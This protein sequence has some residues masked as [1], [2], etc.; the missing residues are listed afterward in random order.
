MNCLVLLLAQRS[1]QRIFITALML[2]LTQRNAGRIS[3][4]NVMSLPPQGISNVLM[5]LL[6]KRISSYALL[7]LVAQR[8]SFNIPMPLPDQTISIKALMSFNDLMPLPAQQ[9]PINAVIPP[10]A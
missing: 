3:I 9:I 10:V 1:V 2:Q 4:N 8:N 7:L 6:A 5:P